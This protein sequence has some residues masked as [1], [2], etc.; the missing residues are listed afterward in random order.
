MTNDRIKQLRALCEAA[1]DGPWRAGR[2]DM[3]SYTFEGPKAF[4]NVYGPRESEHPNMPGEMI[5]T[6]EARAYG[7][8][9][10]E[11]AQFIAEARTALPEAL[12]EVERLRAYATRGEHRAMTLLQAI[13]D[14]TAMQAER[15]EARRIVVAMWESTAVCRCGSHPWDRDRVCPRCAGRGSLD[16]RFIV[17]AYRE[18]LS[19]D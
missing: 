5:P 9:C 6:E 1:A 19:D 11:G 2:A 12:D 8:K 10:I 14:C 7:D 16:W 4:K 13:E 3:V 18:A 17:E 15:D